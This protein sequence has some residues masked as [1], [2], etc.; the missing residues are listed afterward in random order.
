M[1]FSGPGDPVFLE[2]AGGIHAG[3]HRQA[4]QQAKHGDRG[5]NPNPAALHRESRARAC[6]K[7]RSLFISAN[8]LQFLP[9][10]YS[11]ARRRFGLFGHIVAGGLAFLAAVADLQVW[12][13]LGPS[14]L[15]M[16]AGAAAGA[17]GFR[18]RTE[19]GNLGQT[20][21]LAQQAAPLR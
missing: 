18:Q 5:Q 16:A 9:G 15:T 6:R 21:D 20:F 17:I 7:L 10:R 4:P 14:A 13:V 8:F 2:A 1:R 12:P 19:D 3:F 11:L